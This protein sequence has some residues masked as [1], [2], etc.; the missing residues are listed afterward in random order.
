VHDVHARI[1]DNPDANPQVFESE[2]RVG[3]E[4]P[5]AF[6]MNKQAVLSK[7]E[8]VMSVTHAT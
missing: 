5:Y 6:C 8:W 7:D 4:G 2:F 3:Y 1:C